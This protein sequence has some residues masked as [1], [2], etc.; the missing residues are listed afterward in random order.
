MKNG[1]VYWITGLS[2]AGK[3]TIG[4]LF[5]QKIREFKKNV[6]FLDGDA[7]REVFGNDLSYSIEDRKISAMRNARLC[8]FL[9][10]QG[11]DVICCTISMFHDV[12]QWNRQH[13]E[14]YREVYLKVPLNILRKRDR[15]GLYSAL[16]KGQERNVYGLDLEY[17]EPVN[18]DIE[19]LNDGS[20]QPEEIAMLLMNR[21]LPIIE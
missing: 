15:K 10:E 3:T 2:G 20:S 6:I 8:K 17:E 16:E 14:N 18:P 19:I 5:Y 1:C 13:I 21:L 11:M 7:L 12:R 9:S 4:K